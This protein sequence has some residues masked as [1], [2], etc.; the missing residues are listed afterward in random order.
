MTLDVAQL[1]VTYAGQLRAWFWTR[2]PRGDDGLAEELTQAVFEKVVRAADRYRDMDRPSSWLYR[3][4][5]MTLL[6]H[7]A[8]KRP[9]VGLPDLDQVRCTVDAGSEA[10]LAQLVIRDVLPALPAHYRAVLENRFL[11][12]EDPGDLAA[13]EHTTRHTIHL[14]Q[15]R[16]LLASRG[17]LGGAA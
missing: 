14:R 3:I 1:Y 5:T 13:R 6:D 10:H 12:G 7:A 15:A 11:L 2:L 9:D 8:K 4:A 17:L 16:A